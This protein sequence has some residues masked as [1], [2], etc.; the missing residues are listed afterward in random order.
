MHDVWVC[1]IATLSVNGVTGRGTNVSA[2]R[3][4]SLVPREPS[5]RSHYSSRRSDADVD[6]LEPLLAALLQANL[7]PPIN[8]NA[9]SLIG[10]GALTTPL[11]D[12]I[13]SRRASAAR[14]LLQHGADA[15]L[16][17]VQGLTGSASLPPLHGLIMGVVARPPT[18]V[19][20]VTDLLEAL[21]EHGAGV[22]AVDTAAGSEVHACTPLLTCVSGIGFGERHSV[23]SDQ[24]LEAIAL[25]LI[26]A[27]ADLNARDEAQLRPLD[28][29]S[30]LPSLTL[31]NALIAKGADPSPVPGIMTAAVD[32]T[33]M[34]A[35]TSLGPSSSS[36]RTCSA[37]RQQPACGSR[38]SAVSGPSLF[39]S[40]PSASSGTASRARAFFWTMGWT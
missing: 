39:R 29:A 3:R 17:M 8:V 32:G 12:C 9:A 31:F 2:N 25:R 37:T 14:L 38:K 19:R 23:D 24:A 6:G 21:L 33:G 15:S 36:G 7:T 11:G 40:S 13:Y 26:D 27:G 34:G 16:P 22:D 18:Q 35:T 5:L 28:A 1:F 4:R 30:M 20:Q 10:N